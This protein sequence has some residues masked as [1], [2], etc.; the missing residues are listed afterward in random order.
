MTLL[1]TLLVL[2]IISLAIS[3]A[4]AEN[5]N[6]NKPKAIRILFFVQFVFAIVIFGISTYKDYLSGLQ[7]DRIEKLAKEE[8]EKNTSTG[9]FD[10][11]F[12]SKIASENDIYWII[13]T[14]TFQH[15]ST[16]MND[17]KEEEPIKT[18]IVDGKLN[19]S[20]DI[21][22]FN[23]N[24]LVEVKDNKWRANPNFKNKLNYD[25]RGFEVIDDKNNVV[26][27]LNILAGNVIRVQGIFFGKNMAY[28]ANKESLSIVSKTELVTDYYKL[29]NSFDR[30]FEYMGND[31]LH[32]RLPV[33]SN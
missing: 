12:G 4:L 17:D 16:M 30:I 8:S 22:D 10:F 20:I 24:L 29:T 15:W 14:V 3:Y 28:V 13:G 31:W 33:S 9:E 19:F 23:H 1:I 6:I 32:K 2:G 5:D 26:L 7:Q 11:D 21:Y 27:S 18:K 25:N